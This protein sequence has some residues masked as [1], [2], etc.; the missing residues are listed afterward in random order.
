MG[1]DMIAM[2]WTMTSFSPLRLGTVWH[3]L[4]PVQY[5]STGH[6][7]RHFLLSC[8]LR[9]LPSSM[10]RSTATVTSK[11]A[12]SILNG[13]PLLR[14]AELRP[15]PMSCSYGWSITDNKLAERAL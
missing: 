1:H 10:G 3:E 9:L 12:C 15:L 4:N 11:P 7:E 14:W 13:F 8:G 5:P 2:A 6:A